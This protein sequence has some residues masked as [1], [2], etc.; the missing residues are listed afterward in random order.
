MRI[1]KKSKVSWN[2]NSIIKNAIKV[3]YIIVLKL[4]KT[5]QWA[6]NK[7]DDFYC[8]TNDILNNFSFFSSFK[9]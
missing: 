4:V 1:P 7:K 8:D 3:F 5:N 2:L 9:S 6:Y